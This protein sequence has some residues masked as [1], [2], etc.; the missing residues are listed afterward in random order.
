[1]LASF[2]GC[3]AAYAY[4]H[5]NRWMTSLDL[6]FKQALPVEAEASKK[7]DPYARSRNNEPIQD[8]DR[9]VILSGNSSPELAQ[10]IAK[11]L[12]TV[13]AEG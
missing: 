5:Y 7:V 10:A 2:L 1:M 8:A 12:G 6:R 13:L 4:F 11:H 3:S 9:F